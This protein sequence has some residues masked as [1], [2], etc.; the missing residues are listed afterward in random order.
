M[1]RTYRPREVKSAALVYRVNRQINVPEVRLIGENDENIGV[2]T[3]AEAFERAEQAGLDLVEVSPLAKPPVAKIIDFSQFKYQRDK[4]LQKAKARQKKQETKGVRLSTR[5]GTHDRDLRISQAS[6][7][8]DDGHKLKVELQ[9]RGREHQ[10]KDLA[11]EVIE[12]FLREL[13][14]HYTIAIE[15]PL[16]KQGGR[17]SLICY[18]TGKVAKPKKAEE[19]KA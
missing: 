8:L 13:R 16:Q 12:Q 15:Q 4:E 10:H 18:T 2:V 7:F 17:L 5:I 3:T 1:R 19:D 6:K 11:A 14:K 9:L